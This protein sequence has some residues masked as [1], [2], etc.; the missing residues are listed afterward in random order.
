[1]Y[2]ETLAFGRHV[3]PWRLAVTR[4]VLGL[5]AQCALVTGGLPMK[6]QT[7]RLNDD[8]SAKS[9]PTRR[10]RSQSPAQRRAAT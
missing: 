1:M 6:I 5:R 3:Y 8:E 2:D 7:H 4:Y 9:A 10:S